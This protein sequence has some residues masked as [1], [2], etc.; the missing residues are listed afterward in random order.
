MTPLAI[1]LLAVLV[2]CW[3]APKPRR[4]PRLDVSTEPA[5][6]ATATDGGRP[7]RSDLLLP[8]L[9]ALAVLLGSW[10]LAIAGPVVVVV[11]RREQRRRSVRRGRA[12][13]E[14]ALIA[15]VDEIALQL[16]AGRVLAAAVSDAV[17]THA[18]SLPENVRTMIDRVGAGETHEQALADA[19]GRDSAAPEL[20]PSAV[21]VFSSLAVLERSGGPA[22]RAI[23]QLSET[24]RAR[25]TARE[26]LRSQA[27]QAAASATA[28]AALPVVFGG[29]VALLEPKVAQFYF[30]A[31]G[32]A[33]CI[34]G[35][36][37]LTVGGHE[38]IDS[39]IWGE[40]T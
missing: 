35:A 34:V 25:H 30:S 21:L 7:V 3:P 22:I 39:L 24:L 17:A 2:G 40:R 5:D 11:V 19:H 20:P 27:S 6:T 15:M 12:E 1:G 13:S 14:R 26:E 29:F 23:D 31:P 28:L 37:L 16:R 9:P 32:G 18:R 33:A 36:L 38:W 8:L 10:S 4:L